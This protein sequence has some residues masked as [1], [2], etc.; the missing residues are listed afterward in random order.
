MQVPEYYKLAAENDAAI[1]QQLCKQDKS[2]ITF[3]ANS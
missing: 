1:M 3:M 2:R